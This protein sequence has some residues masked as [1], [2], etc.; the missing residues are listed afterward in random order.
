MSD[1]SL[2]SIDVGVF[3]TFVSKLLS[4]TYIGHFLNECFCLL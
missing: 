2:G 3:L 1:V 4:N